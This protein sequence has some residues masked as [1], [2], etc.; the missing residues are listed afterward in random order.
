MCSEQQQRSATF[1][2]IRF[3]WPASPHIDGAFLSL[4]KQLLLIKYGHCRHRRRCRQSII[5]SSQTHSDRARRCCQQTR[6][7][8][9]FKDT[10][11]PAGGAR[12][13]TLSFACLRKRFS[14]HQN[15]YETTTMRHT[16]KIIMNHFP[17]HPASAR[18]IRKE[19]VR[20]D[21]RLKITKMPVVSRTST[22]YA[23]ALTINWH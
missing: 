11:P 6:Q 21:I 19:L 14:R 4:I 9:T 15:R 18:C 2:F 10:L 8:L 1:H 3:R 5:H 22:W 23:L 17:S 13:K 20:T 12:V 16:H 7:L